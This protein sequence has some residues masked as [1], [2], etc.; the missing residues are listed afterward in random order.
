MFSVDFSGPLRRFGPRRIP[1][2]ALGL[3]SIVDKNGHRLFPPRY[4]KSESAEL[5]TGFILPVFQIFRLQELAVRIQVRQ[6][7]VQG[8]VSHF[9]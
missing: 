7:C 8:R 3:F 4:G 6:H 5:P 9:L 2:R 1:A